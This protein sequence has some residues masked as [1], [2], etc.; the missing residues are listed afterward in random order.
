ML[1]AVKRNEKWIRNSVT[2]QMYRGYPYDRSTNF[3][4]LAWSVIC[5]LTT[6]SALLG[7]WWDSYVDAGRI[8]K[9]LADSQ[10]RSLEK[11]DGVSIRS[12]SARTF[13]D[14]ANQMIKIVSRTS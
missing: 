1:D 10:I 13:N 3:V 7:G 6:N 9:E 4:H 8:Y 11:K 14:L 5:S 12:V 2:E